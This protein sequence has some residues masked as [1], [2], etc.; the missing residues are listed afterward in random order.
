MKILIKSKNK[1]YLSCIVIG[2]NFLRQW[3]KYVLPSWKLYCENHKIGL[4]IFT[5][6]LVSRKNAAWKKATWQKMLIGSAILQKKIIVN[7]VC[8]LDADILINPYAPNIF[9]FHIEKKISLVSLRNRLPYD[10]IKTKKKISFYRKYFYDNSY[11]LNSA[12]LFTLKQI[13]KYHK[14]PVMSDEACMGLF[15]FNVKKFAS[16]MKSWFYK[17]PKNISSITGGGDQIH[18][19]YEIQK[20][21]N[22]NWLDYKFQCIWNYEMSNYYPFLYNSKFKNFDLFN[23]CIL[24]SL[25]NNYFLHFAGSWHESGLLYKKKIT[26]IKLLS[27]SSRS[28]HEYLKKEIVAK[29]KS[30][31][32]PKNKNG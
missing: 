14:L 25:Y 3:K 28:I 6:D 13:Y 17:Y 29:S 9:N 31:V 19:N 16:K 21:V 26:K 27:K 23:E 32:L 11:P 15:I 12:I 2:K 7:N 24:N 18:Y 22:V 10:Y 5:D 8:Y 30:R 20:N 1:N 4:I